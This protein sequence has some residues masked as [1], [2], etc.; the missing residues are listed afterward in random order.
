M[1]LVF[2]VLIQLNFISVFCQSLQNLQCISHPALDGLQFI[3]L[4]QQKYNQTLFQQLSQKLTVFKTLSAAK[5]SDNLDICSQY[6]GQQTCCDAELVSLLKQLAFSKYTEMQQYHS[7]YG[8]IFSNIGFS[9]NQCGAKNVD[10]VN[11]LDKNDTGIKEVEIFK[12]QYKQCQIQVIQTTIRF[13]RGQVCSICAGL[14]NIQ[15]YFTGNSDAYL[16]QKSFNSYY[17]DLISSM[18]CMENLQ[19]QFPAIVDILFDKLSDQSEQCNQ[20][21]S[22]YDKML[23][24]NLNYACQGKGC[25]SSCS[26]LYFLSVDQN[27]QNCAINAFVPNNIQDQIQQINTNGYYNHTLNYQSYSRL[28]PQIQKSN[29]FLSKNGIQSYLVD[30]TQDQQVLIEGSVYNNSS[31]LYFTYLLAVFIFS[32]LC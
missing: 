31:V 9:I 7:F 15:T 13:Y 28:L 32:L 16:D 14:D 23:T 4:Q 19:N 25:E 5:T 20:T 30:S 18:Q 27:Q 6:A 12:S 3:I 21:K 22:S 17:D 8:Q 26:N 11:D 10:Q 1:K 29:F 24:D 2:L